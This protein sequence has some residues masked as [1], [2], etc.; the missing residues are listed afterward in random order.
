MGVISFFFYFIEIERFIQDHSI[1][2]EPI[3]KLLITS[4]LQA[5]TLKI[6]TGEKGNQ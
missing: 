5:K 2:L 3:R 1:F 6:Y 4:L